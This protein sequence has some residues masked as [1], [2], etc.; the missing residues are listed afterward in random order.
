MSELIASTV[1][2]ELSG[3]KAPLLFLFTNLIFILLC[4]SLSYF[5]DSSKKLC[6]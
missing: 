2:A 1:R 5:L 3:K 6:L 4:N